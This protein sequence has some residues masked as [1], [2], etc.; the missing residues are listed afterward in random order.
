VLIINIRYTYFVVPSTAQSENFS[1]FR[2]S[3]GRLGTGP[4]DERRQ[5]NVHCGRAGGEKQN[6]QLN[7]PAKRRPIWY[8]GS[9]LQFTSANYSLS[10]PTKLHSRPDDG[11]SKHF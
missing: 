2:R 11:G 7:Y 8:S 1:T 6:D 3:A 4:Q 10:V 9:L 5:E